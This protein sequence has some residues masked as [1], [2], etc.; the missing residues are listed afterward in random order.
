MCSVFNTDNEQPDYS[1]NRN[2]VCEPEL[3]PDKSYC[4]NKHATYPED[5]CY[6][7]DT[8]RDG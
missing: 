6:S 3:G 1:N 7:D 2:N 5:P 4:A 8:N